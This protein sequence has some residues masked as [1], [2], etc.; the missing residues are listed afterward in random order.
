MFDSRVVIAY[1]IA[2]LGI[3]VK[4]VACTRLEFSAESSQQD[5]YK[6]DLPVTISERSL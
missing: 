1:V 2:A 3:A 4:E 6:L 5:V